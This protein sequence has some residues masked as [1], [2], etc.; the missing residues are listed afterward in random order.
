L[1]HVGCFIWVNLV[2]LCA[3]CEAE[4]FPKCT[5]GGGKKPSQ[6]S[7]STKREQRLTFVSLRHAKQ[8]ENVF[9]WSGEKKFVGS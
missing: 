2:P 7:C 6:A 4:Q 5:D 9:L 8:A 1:I 3:T